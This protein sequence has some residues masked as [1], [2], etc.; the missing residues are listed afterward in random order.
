MQHLLQEARRLFEDT[1]QTE[2]ITAAFAPGRINLLGE[3]TDYN[4]GHVLPVAIN[5]GVLV[6]GALAEESNGISAQAGKCNSFNTA[7]V[8]PGSVKGWARYFAGMAWALRQN[9]VQVPNL[10]ISVA[11]NLPMGSGVSSS[12][13]LEMALG[14]LWKQFAVQVPEGLD[15]AKVGKLCENGFV[16]V[17]TGL[18][19]QAASVM[20]KEGHAVHFDVKKETIGYAQVPSDWVVVLCDTKQPRS[21]A[22]SK[23]NDRWNEC[24]TACKILGI[25]SLREA[26]LADVVNMPDSIEKRRAKHVVTENER[27]LQMKNALSSG[28]GKLAGELMAASHASLRDDYE[29][30]CE[31][32][33]IMAESAR[34]SGA[35]GARMTGAG[36]GGAC[37]ALVHANEVDSFLKSVAE[38]FKSRF[39]EEGSFLV[40]KVSDGARPIPPQ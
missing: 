16:G 8:E 12:A 33:D 23:Y 28:D 24:Q 10:N 14:M 25:D 36:F 29:V 31:A 30:S 26:T 7:T 27:V 35:I 39:G 18:M 3:H 19:D 15:L 1:Y 40:C 9:G 38:K 4:L 2:P 22:A 32:L 6:L 5:Y 13:A 34:D 21:L 37:V 20:G 11:S 17:A